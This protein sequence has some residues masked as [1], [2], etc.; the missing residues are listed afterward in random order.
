M[1]KVEKG[2]TTLA[3]L[4]RKRGAI[5]GQITKTT[6]AIE[7]NEPSEVELQTFLETVQKLGTKFDLLKD[8]YYET[9]A[10]DQFTDIETA[11]TE[12]DDELHKLE[13]RLKTLIQDIEKKNSVVDLSV[14]E[15]KDESKNSSDAIKRYVKLPQIPLPTFSG[16][17]DEWNN[18]KI[19]FKNLIDV[20][21]DISN[22]EKLYYLKA[23]LKGEAKAI[24][25]SDDTYESLFKALE[26]RFENKRIIVDTHIKNIMNLS[27]V[28][29]ES[30]KDLRA[31]LDDINRNLRTLKSLNYQRDALSNVLLFHIISDKLDK[32]TRKQFELTLKGT[33]VPELDDFL[34]YLER[35]CQILSSIRSTITP[36]L[37]QPERQR[38]LISKSHKT[39]QVCVVCKTHVHPVYQCIKFKELKL[40]DRINVVKKH[41]LCYNCLSTFHSSSNCHSKGSCYVCKHSGHHTLLHRYSVSLSQTAKAMPAEND[42][43]FNQMPLPTVPD[44][45][46]I[47][48]IASGQSKTVLINTAVVYVRDSL[49]KRKALRA[50]LDSASECSFLTSRAADALGLRKERVNIPICGLSDASVDVKF[51]STAQLSNKEGEAIWELDFLLVP[52]ITDVTPSK[53]LNISALDIPKNI[54]LADPNFHIPQKIDILLGAELFFKLLKEDKILLKDNL[55]LQDSCFGYLVSGSML[56]SS[57]ASSNYKNCFL[58][59][60]NLESLDHTLKS[61]WEIESIDAKENFISDEL[62]YCNEHFQKTHFRDADGTF[63]VQMPFKPNTSET[64]L[65]CSKKVASKRLDQL[66]QRLERDPVMK[67]LYQEFLYEYRALN[68]MVE[69][70]E[71]EDEET[72]YYLPHHGVLRPES[73]T[74]KLRVV[75]NA[76]AKTSSGNSLND[77]L[78]KGGIIQ[79]DLFSILT[80]FRKH[81]FAFSTDIKKM[82]RMIKLNHSQVKLQKILWKESQHSPVKVFELQT[83]TYG[84]AC[85]PFIATRVLQQLASL[86]GKNFPL[87]A[88]VLRQDFYMDDCLSG[89]STLEDFHRLRSELTLL[90]QRGGMELHKWCSNEPQASAQNRTFSLDRNSDSMTVKTLGMLWNCSSDTFSFNVSSKSSPTLTKRC[91]LSEIASIFDPLGLLGPV[92][93]RAKIF[94]QQLWQRKVEWNEPLPPDV[95]DDWHA[96]TEKL[97]FIKDIR[98]PRYVL[99]P[100]PTHTVLHGFADASIKAYGAVIYLTVPTDSTSFKSQLLTS[101]S[102]VAPLKSLTIPRLELSACL[103]L[104]QLVQKVLGAIRHP[105]DSVKLWSD[106][107]IA[108]AWI[109]TSPHLLKTFVSNRVAQIQELSK[110]FQWQH[111]PSEHNPA[112]LISRGLDAKTLASNELWWNGPEPSR[113]SVPLHDDLPDSPS[114]TDKLFL[115]ELKTLSKVTL[116]ANSNTNFFD[117]LIQLT[118]NF[119]KLIRILAFIFRFIENCRDSVKTVGPL[120]VKELDRTEKYIIKHLQVRYFSNE[121]SALKKGSSV[122]TSS[123][124]KF[125]NPFID[126]EGLVR[127]GGRLDNSNLLY[128]HK[129]PVVLP[130]CD[131]FV[132]LIFQYYHKRDFHVG[133]QAL[134]H[135]VRLKYWIL[136]GRSLA[137][138]VVHECVTCFKTKP[139]PV[140]QIMGN[141][142]PERVLPNVPFSNTGLDLCGPFLIKYKNQRKGTLQKVYVAIFVCMVTKAIHLEFVSDL[143]SDAII[144]TLKRFFAR[145]GKSCTIFSDNATNFVGASNQLKHLQNLVSKDEEI[146]GYLTS[147]QINWRF[148]PPRAPNFG[149]LWEAG[150][151]SFKYHLKRVVGSSKLTLEEFLTIVIQI[152]GILNSRPLYPLSSDSD[153]FQVLTPGHFIIGKSLNSLPEPN[154]VEKKEHLLDRWQR[155]QK[156]V[157]VIWKHWSKNYLSHLHQR[158][159]WLFKKP[160]LLEGALVLL[161][162]TQ[163]PVGTWCLGRITHVILGSDGNVRVVDVQTPK[164]NFRRAVSKI[165]ILP[166][167]DN[168]ST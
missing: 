22:E 142:P 1:S 163:I 38:T 158:S 141:L 55:I 7:D 99:Q 89:S 122:P 108:L 80:R 73:Q 13:V 77:L 35:K 63:V 145:R 39:P 102:R 57:N 125:L 56:D 10:D 51:K 147:E 76:S 54:Q 69:V 128:D 60:S 17:F 42:S 159:K 15:L 123:K 150:V 127:V 94:M 97:R 143:T 14:C 23:S 11:L 82:F 140:E 166:I 19:Q 83:V 90:L 67:S 151:K 46:R 104:A 74:T 6:S 113:L 134:L 106:S 47:S 110:D 149:G 66:W 88:D 50:V 120:R 135:T 139:I 167:Q 98:I 87:A 34:V 25:A 165:S 31:F 30:F 28:K 59:K 115:N 91:M 45:P 148:L 4:N 43:D 44:S 62:S 48:L 37:H 40:E 93:S 117:N 49:N 18:F 114:L 32:E 53:K 152:E 85:A 84:T 121:I 27:P 5:K 68:H 61:F 92:T 8:Q 65:G 3:T 130:A 105:V 133:P 95:V 162:D 70:A 146:S 52:K 107:T 124:L 164:G 81:Q 157:Q 64:M 21:S 75:F 160:N 155:S 161:Q 20:D 100:N 131:V 116:T 78:S 36:K 26:S 96:F 9:V 2:E 129:H 12:V 132:K 153:D 33:D 112:D 86:E 16:K 72:G 137:R 126:S 29:S 136:G 79:E 144:A 119:Q 118:N 58:S 154:L 138:K 111:I 41:R 109:K 168:L 156:Y 101:K 71:N 24:E 103:L